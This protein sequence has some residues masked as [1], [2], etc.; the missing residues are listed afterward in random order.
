MP[1]WREARAWLEILRKY[2]I[3]SSTT[4]PHHPWQNEA[5]RRIQ[6]YKKGTN[7]ILDRTGAP[8][9]LWFYALL[10]WVGI[11][12]IL[13]DPHHNGWTCSEVAMGYTPDISAYIHYTFYQPVYYYDESESFPST[14][15]QLGWWLGPT[16][17]CGD[18]LT[19]YILTEKN[20]IIT[21]ST[22]HPATDVKTINYRC[23][24]PFCDEGGR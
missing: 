24:N 7:H 16:T 9:T 23:Q 4:E 19:Y 1:R 21:R 22:I 18:A 6:E 12:N 13:S 5:E 15:E 10:L 8:S 20:T 14:K 17:N 3:S 2:N 11:M